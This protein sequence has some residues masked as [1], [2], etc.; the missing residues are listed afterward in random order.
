VLAS[1]DAV[2]DALRTLTPACD[3][4]DALRGRAGRVRDAVQWHA[5]SARAFRA[6]AD[7]LADLVAMAAAD[8]QQAVDALRRTRAA[9][10]V[11]AATS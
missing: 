7:G 1:I 6:R 11:A 10:L 4:L 5:P 3:R 8:A 9:L 2:D